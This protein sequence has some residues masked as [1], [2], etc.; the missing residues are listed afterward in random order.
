MNFISR[1]KQNKTIKKQMNFISRIKKNKTI[2]KQM[3]FIS[4][5]KQNKTIKR[6]YKI[7]TVLFKVVSRDFLVIPDFHFFFFFFGMT[8]STKC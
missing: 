2:K 5:I 1:I 4:R 7:Y 8:P 6:Q 3:N